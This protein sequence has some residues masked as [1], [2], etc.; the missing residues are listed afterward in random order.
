MFQLHPPVY[1]LTARRVIACQFGISTSIKDTFLWRKKV[2]GICR[3]TVVY[4]GF[5]QTGQAGLRQWP[6]EWSFLPGF[7]GHMRILNGLF[8][9]KSS[10]S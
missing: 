7:S 9:Y 1:A 6:A 5:S 10:M 2:I 8:K 3:F 4:Y